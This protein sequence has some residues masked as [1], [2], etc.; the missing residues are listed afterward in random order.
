MSQN[1]K[2][3]ADSKLKT[4]PEDRQAAIFEYAREHTLEETAKWLKDDGFQTSR[5]A[6]SEFVSW[7]GLQE[8]LRKNEGTVNQLLEKLKEGNPDYSEEWLQKAGH[9]FF[10]ALAIEEKDSLT[11]KRTQDARTRQEALRLARD[12]FERETCE[13]F[14]KWRADQE[15]NRIAE[16]NMPNEERIKLLRRHWFK[17]VDELEK[18]GTV[19]LPE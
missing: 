8:Q 13:L 10:S 18:S 19:K 4:L 6:L 17:D 11:W 12:Q 9:I 1:K 14:L 3:R 16:M 5:S 7:Y 15:S 2:P